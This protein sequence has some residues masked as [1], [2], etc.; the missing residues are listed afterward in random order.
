MPGNTKR[1]VAMRA[2]RQEDM[3][4]RIKNTGLLNQI[5]DSVDEMDEIRQSVVGETRKTDEDGKETVE[6]G[7]MAESW[8]KI[9]MIQAINKTRLALLNKV[10]P[11]LKHVEMDGELGVKVVEINR[12]G[13]YDDDEDSDEAED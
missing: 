7:N 11:D 1:A 10:L 9:N 2:E 3:R 13:V 8:T 5:I 12:T 6:S 4:E